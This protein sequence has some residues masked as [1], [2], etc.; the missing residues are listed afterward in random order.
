M[1]HSAR[2]EPVYQSATQKVP[3]PRGFETP[4]P[5]IFMVDACGCKIEMQ[6]K[7]LVDLKIGHHDL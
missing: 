7:A 6:E 3:R 2:M 5:P 4:N 1:H